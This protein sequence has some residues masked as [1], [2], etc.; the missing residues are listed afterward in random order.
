MRLFA[1]LDLD[2]EIRKR[3]EQYIQR[4][5]SLAP[6]VRWTAVESLHITVRFIGERPDAVVKQIEDALASVQAGTFTVAVHGAG[7]F[8]RPNAARVF[9]VGI[10]GDGLAQLAKSVDDALGSI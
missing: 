4:I 3:I 1:A 7:F 2:T 6:D 9:W 8:P 5:R 10:E